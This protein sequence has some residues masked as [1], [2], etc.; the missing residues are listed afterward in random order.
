MIGTTWP[1]VHPQCHLSLVELQWRLL[2]VLNNKRLGVGRDEDS[3]RFGH[4][5]KWPRHRGPFLGRGTTGGG[6][7]RGNRRQ[8]SG[9]SRRIGFEH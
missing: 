4:G 5:G 8:I 2:F 3:S 7:S 6:R 9:A 1:Q